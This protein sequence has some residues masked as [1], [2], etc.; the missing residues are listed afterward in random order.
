MTPEFLTAL[1]REAVHARPDL[2]SLLRDHIA[3][4]HVDI[5]TFDQ[6][7]LDFLDS[8]IALEPRGPEWTEILKR[9]RAALTPYCDVPFVRAAIVLPDRIF[10]IRVHP[11]TREIIHWEEC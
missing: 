6:T 11:D 8:Q 10:F 1:V 9:R 4:A 2:P 3:D 5:S 7:Y